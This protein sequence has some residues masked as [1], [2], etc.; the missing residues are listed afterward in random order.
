MENNI[1]GKLNHRPAESSAGRSLADNLANDAERTIGRHRARLPA[2]G[3]NLRGPLRG[4]NRVPVPVQLRG[5]DE[6]D[7]RGEQ[8]PH[9]GRKKPALSSP[10]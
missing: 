3:G 10:T 1:P 8:Q 4:Y 7:L 6:L 5:K 9:S 2:M